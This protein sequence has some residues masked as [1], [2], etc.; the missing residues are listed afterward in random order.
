MRKLAV[1]F[2]PDMMEERRRSRLPVVLAVLF[3]VIGLAP[4]A[5][6]G[7]SICLGNWKEIMG[8][9]TDVRT[10]VLDQVQES[11]QDLKRSVLG[12]ITP[13]FRR[14]PW[15]PQTVLISGAIVMGLAMLMLRK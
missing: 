13:Y 7:V 9:S 5:L 2:E 10:P 6:E 8:V 4:L 15:D 12:E 3:L 14:L 11:L 1:S